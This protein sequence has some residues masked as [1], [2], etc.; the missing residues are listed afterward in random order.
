MK[1]P[2]SIGGIVQNRL[3]MVLHHKAHIGKIQAS[4]WSEEMRKE[5][6]ELH[7]PLI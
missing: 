7:M 4:I 3:C 5:C 2:L 1:L 6:E